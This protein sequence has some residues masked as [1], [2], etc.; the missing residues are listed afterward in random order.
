MRVAAVRLALLFA[1][2]W[3]VAGVFGVDGLEA[4]SSARLLRPHAHLRHGL[5]ANGGYVIDGK[6][7]FLIALSNPPP[8]SGRTPT[9]MPGPWEIVRAGVNLVRVGPKWT[10]WTPREL[11]QVLAWDRTAAQLGVHT[12]VRLNAF[13]ATQP[14]WRG[15]AHLAS[16]VH[17]LTRDRFAT[18][19]GLWQGADEPWSRGISAG[20]LAFF[21]CRVSSR[22]DPR[23]CA[24]EPTL[25]HHHPL[26]TILAPTGTRAALAPY[27]NV[28]DSL[29]VDVYPVTLNNSHSLDL[30]MVGRWTRR[31]APHHPRPLRLDDATDL[32]RTRIQ[33]A[34][35][36]VRPSQRLPG[37][38]HGLR[39]DHQRRTR[40]LLLRGRKPPLLEPR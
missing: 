35:R 19:I 1:C 13:A 38:L 8:L 12:W 4:G 33:Q 7:T 36:R 25:D 15:D 31:I 18:G 39:R 32:F 2:T 9:G 27:T 3:S 34:D 37:A 28:T 24:E 20:S 11:E 30:H 5:D 26:V 10:G 6:P 40:H 21:Y 14:R 16:I 22:G 29:G 17:A 23:E